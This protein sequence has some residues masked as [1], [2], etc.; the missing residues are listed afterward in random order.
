MVLHSVGNDAP[1]YLFGMSSENTTAVLQC[2]LEKNCVRV[3][4]GNW[5]DVPTSWVR[6]PHLPPPANDAQSPAVSVTTLTN[7][8]GFQRKDQKN[9][10]ISYRKCHEALHE[11]E[12]L[13]GDHQSVIA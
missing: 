7:S 13:I 4:L 6:T 5:V 11:A 8:P 1:R 12:S 10:S 2:S 9:A 3:S